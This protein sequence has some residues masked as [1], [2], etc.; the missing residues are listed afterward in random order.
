MNKT[1]AIVVTVIIAIM[2]ALIDFGLFQLW[3]PGFVALTGALAIIGFVAGFYFFGSGLSEPPVSDK[4]DDQNDE[5]MK[6][7]APHSKM[8]DWEKDNGPDPAERPSPSVPVV[9]E[10]GSEFTLGEIMDEYREEPEKES[11]V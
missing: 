1:K 7:L 8:Y 6:M 5:L 11:E 2:L 4:Q 9:D 10:D 3:F